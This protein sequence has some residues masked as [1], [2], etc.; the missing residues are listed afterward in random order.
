M[1]ALRDQ[2]LSRRAVMAWL[3]GAPVSIKLPDPDAARGDG[4]AAPDDEA[5]AMKWQ[6]VPSAAWEREARSA[7]VESGIDSWRQRLDRYAADCAAEAERLK[8]DE[9]QTWRGVRLRRS[10]ERASELL[11]FVEELHRDLDP[12][13]APRTWADLAAGCQHLVVKYLGGR[14]RRRWPDEER[15]LAERVDSAINRLGDLRRHRRRPLAR[16]LP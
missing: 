16:R 6:G 3:A 4:D 11:A 5:T 8:A 15:G 10:A 7:R 1:L 14:L 12:Q 9:D 2:G 13:P